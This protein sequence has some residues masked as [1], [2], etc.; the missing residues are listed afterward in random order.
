MTA[1]R[2]L[3]LPFVWLCAF[4]AAAQSVAT[5]SGMQIMQEVQ[6]RHLL[7]KSIYEELTLILTDRLGNRDTRNLRRYSKTDGAGNTR[8]LLL[9][10]APV[11]IHGVGLLA[12]RDASGRTSIMVYLPADGHERMQPVDPGADGNIMGTDFSLEQMIGE[13]TQHHQYVLAGQ[14][15]SGNINYYLID[16][17]GTGENV[18]TASP[19]RRHYVR[20]DSY[21]I[22]RTDYLDGDGHLLKQKTLH[23]L[24]QTGP[25]SWRAGMVLMEDPVGQHSTLLKIKRTIFSSE[26]VPEEVFTRDW[27]Y[28]NQPPV[29]AAKADDAMVA[30]GMIEP[31]VTPDH[32]R[33]ATG[34]EGP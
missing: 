25:E 19:I 20:E 7:D 5:P 17:Y 24:R 23:D 4:S 21:Y 22:T 15:K 1:A 29:I 8:F 14:Q 27:L 34:P 31:A 9:F 13:Q 30:P 26:Y 2:L 11:E 10:D 18:A 16:V 6:R 12:E 3:L 33:P 28:R 32:P